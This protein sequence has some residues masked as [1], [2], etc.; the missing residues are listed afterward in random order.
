MTATWVDEN[1]EEN[2]TEDNIPQ[3]T[4]EYTI[5]DGVQVDDSFDNEQDNTGYVSETVWNYEFTL[6]GDPDADGLLRLHQPALML[7]K[8]VILLMLIIMFSFLIILH[9]KFPMYHLGP[10]PTKRKAACS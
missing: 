9:Q 4:A 5:V 3:V 6:P 8:T 7:P 2:L 10:T 1:I